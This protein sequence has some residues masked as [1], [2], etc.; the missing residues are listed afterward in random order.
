M[1]CFTRYGRC[2]TAHQQRLRRRPMSDAPKPAPSAAAGARRDD[3]RA[4]DP[5]GV[6]KEHGLRFSRPRELI[7]AYLLGGDKHVSAESLYFDL[8]QRG[9]NLSLSTVYLNLGVLAEA[10]LVREFKGSNGQSFYDSNVTP[11]YHV[12]CRETGRIMDVPAPMIDG[13]PLGRYLKETIEAATGWKVD[14]PRL[15]LTGLSPDARNDRDD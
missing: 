2:T 3:G 4:P 1:L 15:S 10:G 7:L 13:K 11:H 12:V 8:K 5:R 9:E 14:E 6:L